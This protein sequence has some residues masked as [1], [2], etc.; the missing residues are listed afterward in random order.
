MLDRE[1][2]IALKTIFIIGWLLKNPVAISRS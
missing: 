2:I 1:G